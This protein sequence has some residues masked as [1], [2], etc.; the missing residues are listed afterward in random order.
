MD[1]NALVQ[2][3]IFQYMSV[4]GLV[5]SLF[6]LVG[7]WF[8]VQLLRGFAERFG[9]RFADRRLV[10]QQIATLARFGM[11]FA[12]IISSVLLSFH[13]TEEMTLA[14]GGT[15][16]VSLGIAFKDLTSSLVAGITILVDKPFQVGDRV[17]FGGY[18]GEV[19]EIGIRS[20]R[21][22]TLDDN[23]VTIPNS[24]FLT[25]SVSTGNAGALDMLI[26]MD[27]LIGAD[28]DVRTARHIVS[29]ALT[30]CRYAF[31][32][33][34]WTVLTSQIVHESYF[35]IRLRAKVY[36]MDVIYEKALE[37]DVT[38]RVLDGFREA[39]IQPPSI[40]HRALDV[41][42]P[43]GAPTPHTAPRLARG[44]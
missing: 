18:Y 43:E 28:Q 32:E 25:D 35:A 15:V 2:N 40:L 27:F 13:L 10:I 42:G 41:A 23:L 12:A 5:T 3:N 30:S 20:V 14:L 17:A 22:V 8:A 24:K 33:K 37:S 44:A 6:L 34:P 9:R 4:P 38:E 29:D 19:K 36:V 7:T 16:A 21:L 26:Q 39:G 31:L 1:P 11:Y